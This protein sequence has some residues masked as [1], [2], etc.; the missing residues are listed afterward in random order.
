MDMDSDGNSYGTELTVFD[1]NTNSN[2]NSNTDCN[3]DSGINCD[4]NSIA[5]SNDA[6]KAPA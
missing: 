6:Y 2:A 1:S 5:R 3:A 4:A